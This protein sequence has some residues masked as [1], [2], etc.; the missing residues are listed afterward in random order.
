MSESETGGRIHHEI[1]A[2]ATV[3]HYAQYDNPDDIP[4]DGRAAGL[5]EF[6]RTVIA[7]IGYE[8]TCGERFIFGRTAA[9]HLHDVNTGSTQ[10]NPRRT[11]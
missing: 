8:C 11:T 7:H 4:S 1:S 5:I 10:N 9:E 6:D 3:Y 2:R